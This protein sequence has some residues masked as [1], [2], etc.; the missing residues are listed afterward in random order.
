M[1][2]AQW[3]A[4][5]GVAVWYP[6]LFAEY[7]A[8]MVWIVTPSGW[9]G[10]APRVGPRRCEC[11]CGVI[12]PTQTGTRE[13]GEV[14]IDAGGEVGRLSAVTMQPEPIALSIGDALDWWAV[15]LRAKRKRED[16]IEGFA[17][18][19]RTCAHHAGWRTIADVHISGAIAFLE[20]RG[21]CAGCPQCPGCKRPW[22]G[23]TIDQCASALR[24]FGACLTKTEKWGKDALAHLESSG[25]VG[26]RGDRA[27]TTDELRLLIRTALRAGLSDKRARRGNRPLFWAFLALTGLRIGDESHCITWGDLSADCTEY[28]SN[29]AWSKNRKRQRVPINRE[30][31]GLLLEH[32]ESVPHGPGDRVFPTAPFHPTFTADRNAAGIAATDSRGDPFAPHSCRKWLKTTLGQLGV[33]N[34]VSR[35]ILRHHGGLDGRYDHAGWGEMV[36]AVNRLPALWPENL[37]IHTRKTGASEVD[38]GNGPM[39]PAISHESAGS[40]GIEKMNGTPQNPVENSVGGRPD[41]ARLL[42]T[43]Q[44]LRS[45]RPATARSALAHAKSIPGRFAAQNDSCNGQKATELSTPPGR[46][47]VLRLAAEGYRDIIRAVAGRGAGR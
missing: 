35:A 21:S 14:L 36:E 20:H 12:L 25:A 47:E 5:D 41:A 26:G 18:Y 46:S 33:R 1:C 42:V 19:V 29:P 2:A 10:P 27:A 43:E 22:A 7:A 37:V 4:P 40:L 31:A 16:S 28:E 45:G 39:Y 30:L 24:S 15:Y 44:P 6:G 9:V 34:A 3:I 8:A 17:R 38:T 13:W 23:T 32:R 11:G